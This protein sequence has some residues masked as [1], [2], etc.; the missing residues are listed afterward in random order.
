MCVNRKMEKVKFNSLLVSSVAL[1]VQQKP[2]VVRNSTVVYRLE[3]K[4]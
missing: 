4:L 3:T 1:K 2:L